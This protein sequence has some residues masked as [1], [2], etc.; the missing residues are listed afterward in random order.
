MAKVEELVVPVK[1]E[2]DF[3]MDHTEDAVRL[4]ESCINALSGD[5]RSVWYRKEIDEVVDSLLELWQMLHIPSL[6]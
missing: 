6:N 3:A 5:G 1:F 4:I 2:I